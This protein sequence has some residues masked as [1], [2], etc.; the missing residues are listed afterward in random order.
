MS[1]HTDGPWETSV[2][3]ENQW[4][5]CEAG[6][7]DMI[8]S[9]SGCDHQ[10]EQARLIAAAPDLLKACLEARRMVTN[11]T[12]NWEIGVGEMLDAAI[13]KADGR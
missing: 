13:D 4:D 8:A 5:V 12:G 2:N 10:E 6:G 1:K 3:S 7:G 9:L 11:C